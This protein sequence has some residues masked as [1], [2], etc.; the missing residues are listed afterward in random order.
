MRQSGI[1][2]GA[3]LMKLSEDNCALVLG[4]DNDQRPVFRSINC[5][6]GVYIK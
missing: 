3:D 2:S 1:N 4:L 5:F 6:F